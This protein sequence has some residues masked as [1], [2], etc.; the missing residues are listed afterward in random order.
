M[1]I[2]KKD[3]PM[4][5]KNYEI[6]SAKYLYIQTLAPNL[7]EILKINDDIKHTQNTKTTLGR[8]ANYF[9]GIHILQSFDVQKKLGLAFML[10]L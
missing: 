6:K 10:L 2:L 3:F 9:L 7:V 5:F 8:C 4:F 1:S